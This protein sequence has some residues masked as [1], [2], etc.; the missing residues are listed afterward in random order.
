MVK[1]TTEQRVRAPQ[2]AKRLA[3]AFFSE[4]DTIAEDKRPE[5]AKAAQA[6]IR[7]TMMARREKAKTASAKMRTGKTASAK[8][9]TSAK[10]ARKTRGVKATPT[11]RA[12]QPEPAFGDPQ[13]TDEGSRES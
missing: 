1:A 4:L 8:A 7:E 3:Q 12:K 13:E 10:T 9:T 11:R 2:G 5:V 6:I